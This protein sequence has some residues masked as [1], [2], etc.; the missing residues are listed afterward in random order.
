MLEPKERDERGR[1]WVA[2][3][4]KHLPSAQVMIP[5]VLGWSP[6][7]G[8]PLPLP[9]LFPPACALCLSLSLSVK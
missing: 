2:H 6:A 9:L 5:G 3:L 7:S 1:T 4:A 8:S